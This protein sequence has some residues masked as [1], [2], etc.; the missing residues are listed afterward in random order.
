MC[1]AKPTVYHTPSI[2]IKV[3]GRR[4]EVLDTVMDQYPPRTSSEA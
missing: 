2:D 1:I 4:P 3:F